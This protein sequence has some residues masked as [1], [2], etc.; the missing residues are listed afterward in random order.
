MGSI[1]G[2]RPTAGFATGAISSGRCEYYIGNVCRAG[3]SGPSRHVNIFALRDLQNL[4][5]RIGI[6]GNGHCLRERPGNFKRQHQLSRFA[7]TGQSKYLEHRSIRDG[8]SSVSGRPD[9]DEHLNSR[10]QPW[11]TLA[12]KALA[13]TIQYQFYPNGADNTGAGV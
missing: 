10:S 11:V 9:D 5:W 3:R 8:E 13:L 1:D 6:A 2:D 12:G 7:D 4:E